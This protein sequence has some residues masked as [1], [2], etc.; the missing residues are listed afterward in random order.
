[1]PLMSII[2][3]AI[4]CGK[5]SYLT[6]EG[7]HSMKR[8]RV[9]VTVAS[10]A[11][12][13]ALALPGSATAEQA[14]DA[15]GAAATYALPLD[16]EAVARDEYDDPHHDYPAVDLP[17]AEGSQAYASVGGTAT[18]IDDSS[19]GYGV[20]IEGEDGAVYV[21]CHFQSPA[22]ASGTVAAGDPVGLTGNTGSSTGPHLHYQ[23]KVDGTLHC[24]Q[25]Q[26]LAIYD[27]ATPPAPADLPTS[28][29]S[30]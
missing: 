7:G 19:C 25:E 15:P 22:T 12:V 4:Q 3:C 8:L 21:Y 18:P 17:A 28:G 27:G 30:N 20:Q 14:Q 9:A 13:S 29:C 23:M 10:L 6:I 5:F 16:K 1:M 2:G 26:L 11:A 24:P